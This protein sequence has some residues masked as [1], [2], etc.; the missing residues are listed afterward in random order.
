MNPLSLTLI[1]VIALLGYPIGLLIARL[2]KEELQAGKRW[3]KLLIII[4]AIAIATSILFA[5]DE[6]LIFLVASFAFILL[7]AL[8]SLIQSNKL[9]RKKK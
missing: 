4:S 3:F 8:A 6:I 7:L 9:K 5:T 1:I 2:T